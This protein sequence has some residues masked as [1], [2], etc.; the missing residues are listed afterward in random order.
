MYVYTPKIQVYKIDGLD[1]KLQDIDLSP[2]LENVEKIRIKP[3]RVNETTNL[4]LE[5]KG[6]GELKR[7]SSFNRYTNL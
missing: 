7:E 3:Q 5:F 1:S 2:A 4:R 6:C